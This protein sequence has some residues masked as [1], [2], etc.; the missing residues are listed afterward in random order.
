MAMWLLIL[1]GSI[2]A[3]LLAR[4]LAAATAVTAEAEEFR[5]KL[6]L[7][8]AIETVAADLLINGPRSPF[9]FVPAQRD[10]EVSGRRV[11]IEVS[12][13][14]GKLDANSADLAL[15]DRALGGLGWDPGVRALLAQQ[16]R[17]RRDAREPLRSMEE[18]H[19][20]AARSGAPVRCLDDTF[21]VHSGRSE[22]DPAFAPAAVASALGNRPAGQRGGQIS[23]GIPLRIEARSERGGARVAILR[24]G[25]QLDRPLII[26]AWNS[27]CLR[28]DFVG[29]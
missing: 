4:S 11:Q 3:L 7:E 5:D 6:A 17:S 8:A 13:E 26:S 12:A 29:N 25:A 20:L 23:T 14:T 18:L 24:L 28:H 2:A 22:L 1:C 16:L 19:R 10:V 15:I 27:G 21:T 9:A